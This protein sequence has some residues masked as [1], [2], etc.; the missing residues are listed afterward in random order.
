MTPLQWLYIGLAPFAIIA[1]I[2]VAR[3]GPE[4]FGVRV[5][6]LS[7][8][9]RFA[10]YWLNFVGSIF[11]WLALYVLIGRLWKVSSLTGWDVV[12]DLVCFLIA[13]WGITG[14]LPYMLIQVLPLKVLPAW[15]RELHG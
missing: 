15:L 3:Y 8:P 10:Q 13:F 1:S 12:A 4:S 2:C 9:E 11:G 5:T 7:K 14:Q 6:T